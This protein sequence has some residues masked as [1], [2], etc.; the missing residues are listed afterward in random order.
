M[1]APH[2]SSLR[3]SLASAI[4]HRSAAN[5]LLDGIKRTQLALNAALDKLNADDPLALDVDYGDIAIEK[6]FK[7]DEPAL[8]ARH[9]ATL[10][11]TFTVA[12]SHRSLANELVDS[13][14]EIQAAMNAL[15]AKLDAEG[16]SLTDVDYADTLSVNLILADSPVLPAQHKATVRRTLTVAMSHR[17][18]ASVIADSVLGLQEAL[19]AALAQIDTGNIAGE[20]AAFKVDVI[21]PDL[22]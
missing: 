12:L 19:N 20:M 3:R 8:P 16:G 21:E 2:K 10:R 6:L 17:K 18:L 7:A 14:E 22:A 1:A 11:R 13:M 15:L 9:R 4:K 5:E